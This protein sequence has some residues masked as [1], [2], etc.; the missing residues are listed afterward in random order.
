MFSLR[1]YSPFCVYLCGLLVSQ[2]KPKRRHN[3]FQ[4]SLICGILQKM[5]FLRYKF[6][7]KKKKKKKIPAKLLTQS[8]QR[9]HHI[10]LS[11]IPASLLSCDL[12]YLQ[13][14]KISPTA[15]RIHQNSSNAGLL[16]DLRMLVSFL[17]MPF[18][19]TPVFLIQDGGVL[20]LYLI[21]FGVPLFSSLLWSNMYRLSWVLSL[22][23]RFLNLLSSA[24]VS[25]PTS[26]L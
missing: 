11:L 15:G 5:C 23:F 21:A 3:F 4:N 7:Y 8:S 2:Y 25:S 9:K 12:V 18:I 22:A 10:S 19:F 17:F 16:E 1:T 26:V 20:V 13:H 24:A 6:L 14:L